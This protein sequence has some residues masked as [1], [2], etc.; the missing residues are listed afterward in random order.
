MRF[1]LPMAALALVV[2][3]ALAE[4]DT[5]SLWDIDDARIAT[6]IEIQVDKSGN[7]REIEFHVDPAVVPD[8]VRA[9]MTKLHPGGKHV[10]AEIER[11]NGITYY[12]VTSETDGI[13]SEAMFLADGTLHS[14]ENQVAES[15]VPDGVRAAIKASFPEGTVNMWEEIRDGARKL[16]EYHVKLTQRAHK[17]KAAVSLTGSLISAVREVPAEIEVPISVR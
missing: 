17:I 1:A 11:Q 10:D 7:F 5:S 3:L 9:A 12:E 8:A 13:E 6:K 2:G 15:T 14:E 4:A 16:V